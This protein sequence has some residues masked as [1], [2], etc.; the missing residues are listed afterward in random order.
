MLDRCIIVTKIG[1]S[2]GTVED[3]KECLAKE[4]K[5]NSRGRGLILNDQ[6]GL[7]TF[8]FFLPYKVRRV[9]DTNF[10][11][12]ADQSIRNTLKFAQ[13]RSDRP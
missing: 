7:Q 12:H 10:S 9:Y 1:T 13:N 8:E 3:L 6:N 2:E 5:G 11:S 4:S